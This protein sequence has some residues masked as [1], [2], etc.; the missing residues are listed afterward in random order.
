MTNLTN[1]GFP[2]ESA[3][4]LITTKVPIASPE[5]T[6]ADVE[7]MLFQKTEEFETINYIYIVN[8]NKKL[9]GVISVKDVFRLPKTTQLA[10]VMVKEMIS[11]RAHADQERVALLALKHNLKAIPVVD[12]KNCFLGA[13]PSDAILHILHNENI[14]DILR[15]AGV[16]KFKDPA[17]SI[18]QA[19]SAVHFYKRFPWLILGLFGGIAAA[20]VVE[21]FESALRAQ[22]ILAAFIPM[23]VYMADAV[24]AQVQ[25]IFIRSLALD[26]QLNLKRYIW[27]EA[28]VNFFIALILGMVITTIS[29]FWW[30][31]TMLGFVLGLSIFATIF[32][33]TVIA[34]FLPWF[35]SKIKFDPAIASGPLATIIRDMLSLIIYFG[36]AQIMLNLFQI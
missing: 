2:S 23:I 27:R 32:V 34:I 11:A 10:K 12:K 20:L 28:K 15:F 16:H 33:A 17:M 14:E 7:K 24:G 26:R 6:I 30:H 5:A 25:T 1:Q 36:I 22:L 35:F 19:S 29:F 8:R 18:I 4:R 21:Y 9:K 31:S 3:G 13:V